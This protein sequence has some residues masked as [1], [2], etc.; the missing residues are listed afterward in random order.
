MTNTVAAPS[1]PG[2]QYASVVVYRNVMIPM[3]DGVRLVTDIYLPSPDGQHAAGGA[4][5]VLLS[6]TP[7]SKQRPG[8]DGRA[9]A[10]EQ[11]LRAALNGFAV[12]IQDTRGRYQ[13]EGQFRSMQDDGPDGWDTLAWL[14]RQPWCNRRVGMYGVSYLGATQMMLAPLRP[15]YLTAAFSEQPSSDEFTDRTFHSG[16]LTLANVEGWAVNSSGEQYNERLPEDLRARAERELAEYRALGPRA[17]ELLPLEDMPW[18]CLIPGIWQDVLDHLEDP[19]FFAANN[20]RSRLHEIAIPIYHLGGWFDPFLR[21][22][23]D[24]YKGAAAVNANQRLILGPWTHG[25]M[26][27]NSAGD[28]QF[29]DA[30]FDDFGYA[31][32]WHDRWLRDGAAEPAQEH[33]VIIY[34]MG[35]NRWR[36]EDAWPLPGTRVT[37][38]YLRSGGLLSTDGP[39]IDEPDTYVYDPHRPMPSPAM[40]RN[41]VTNLLER[42]DVL[43]YATPPLEDPVEVT[44]EI[45]A[46]LFAAT[47][48]PDTDWML[49]VVDVQPDGTAFHVVDGLMRARYRK[50]RTNPEPL[51][52]GTV[53]RYE[54]NLWA[55]SLVFERGHRIGLVVSSSNFPKYDRHPNVYADMRK[56]TER[57]FVTASQTIHHSDEFPSAVHLPIVAMPEHQQWIVN[58][59]PYRAPDGPIAA[60][61][62]LS[63]REGEA[64]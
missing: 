26:R 60:P 56:V 48:A 19:T 45:T 64:L 35:A 38:Y 34:V 17:F 21:N 44:G 1:E 54:I 31:L 52:A 25:G 24:H 61:I 43:V 2:R 59:M 6:R 12:A 7:Y 49:R 58:P 40:G 16:A 22:T 46:T 3:R 62:E 27:D 37:S 8:L 5:A 15:P 29:P 30:G 13:S 23:I 36:A 53:E 50:A 20:V 18:L 28:T 10:Q 51:M 9:G 63:H 42:G 57:D 39:S 33:L 55:T 41:I 4:F 47:S 32:A 14:G 11:A